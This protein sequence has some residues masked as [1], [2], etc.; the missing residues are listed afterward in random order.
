MNSFEDLADLV[1]DAH[2]ILPILTRHFRVVEDVDLFI[3]GLAE[4]PV[5]GS[6]VG[7]TF[8]CILGLQFQKV[9][10]VACP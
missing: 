1:V 10:C 8:G 3:L 5:R 4:K 7:P 6:L 9:I 2:R